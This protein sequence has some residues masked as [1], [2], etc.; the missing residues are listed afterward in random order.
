MLKVCNI[1]KNK[2]KSY[3]KPT[4]EIFKLVEQFDKIAVYA[5]RS[6]DFDAF[7]S[8]F[9][10]ASFLK[11]YYPEKKVIALGES[12]PNLNGSLYPEMEMLPEEWDNN[13]LAIVVDTGNTARISDKSYV[14]SAKLIKIDH[15][16]NVEPY[17]DVV[18]VDDTTVAVSEILTVLFL[19]TKR[20][21]TQETATYLYTG[22]VGD[23]GRFRY[24]ATTSLTFQV[25][26]LLLEAGVDLDSVYNK[27]YA[28][29]HNE[30]RLRAYI[31]N[32]HFITKEGFA[33]Y[34]LSDAKLQ[35][36]GTTV[37]VAKEQVNI[38]S[39]FK[40]VPV[41]ASIIENKDRNEWRVSMRSRKISLSKFA[42]KWHG[43]GHAQASGASI[44][45]GE[46]LEQFVADVDKLLKKHQG[47][48]K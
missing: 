37:E 11:T 42:A 12:N 30:L 35:E 6:P 25:A 33:Y 2:V 43:G 1:L 10:V 38:F 3:E 13:F 9:A 18:F 31:L 17:G 29:S 14:K 20:K 21:I 7:G 34:V 22:I 23:S 5:H 26:A 28:L 4:Q 8:M 15:H 16:P 46:T 45:P 19:A 32:N 36:L 41:W 44:L 47:S 48:K 27:I 40:N 24:R 39:D